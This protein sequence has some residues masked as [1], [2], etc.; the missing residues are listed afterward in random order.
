MMLHFQK[1]MYPYGVKFT[2]YKQF[3]CINIT[4]TTELLLVHA[5]L[6]APTG[7]ADATM[8]VLPRIVVSG[9]G[10]WILLLITLVSSYRQVGRLSNC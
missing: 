2:M 10:G 3:L 5:D 7:F 6:G 1:E 9:S 8:H 4:L